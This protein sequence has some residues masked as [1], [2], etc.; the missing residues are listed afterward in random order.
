MSIR[1]LVLLAPLA[2][3]A[4]GKPAK[5]AAK[6][7]ADAA[8]ATKVEPAKAAAEPPGTNLYQVVAI[9]RACVEQDPKGLKGAS[10]SPLVLDKYF[11]IEPTKEGTWKVTF[12][13]ETPSTRP[14]GRSVEIDAGKTLC[15]GAAIAAPAPPAGESNAEAVLAAAAKCASA[16]PFNGHGVCGKALLLDHPT[17]QYMNASSWLVSFPEESPTCIPPGRD[18]VIAADGSSCSPAPMD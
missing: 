2:L 15:D 11:L 18:L 17:L 5:Q 7:P 10:G 3:T 12:T 1:H 16:E 4:C 8:A 6:P 14:Y 9:A 13:E